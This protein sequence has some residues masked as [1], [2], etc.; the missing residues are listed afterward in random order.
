ML[1]A[2]PFSAIG[3][4]W[5]LYLLGYPMSPA[6]WVGLIALLGEDADTGTFMVLYL[7][8]AWSKAVVEG[9]MR[10]PADLREAILAG[11]ARRIRPKFMTVATVFLGLVRSLVNGR[12]RGSH[13][14]D[15]GANG[16]WSGDL[17]SDGI[18]RLSGDLRAVEVPQGVGGI[19]CIST[20]TCLP[21]C[22]L[23]LVPPESLP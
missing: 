21:H 7:D 2:V 17:V 12:R 3:A 13:E 18:D 8:L 16:G 11:A 23:D 15:R 10:T 4:V 6:V 19:S 22:F 1:L 9:R 14:A 5:S 20:L